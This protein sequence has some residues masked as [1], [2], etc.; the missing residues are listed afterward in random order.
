MEAKIVEQGCKC[1][2][3]WFVSKTVSVR[4][5]DETYEAFREAADA[6][7]RSLSNFVTSAALAGIPPGAVR[8]RRA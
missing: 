2:Q 5:S 7:Q 6:Q 1:G 3:R 4:L 8:R